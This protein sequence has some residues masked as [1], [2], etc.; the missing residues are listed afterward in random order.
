MSIHNI[1]FS[2]QKEKISPN[3]P[4]SAAMEFF[5]GTEGGVRTSPG[6]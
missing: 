6:K 4:K 3:Y 2:I 1:S 5:E